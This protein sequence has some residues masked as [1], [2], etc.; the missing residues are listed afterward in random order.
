[1]SAHRLIRQHTFGRKFSDRENPINAGAAVMILLSDDNG[2]PSSFRKK[3]T[4][5][6]NVVSK[7]YWIKEGCLSNA[8]L[9]CS[10]DMSAEYRAQTM[11]FSGNKVEVDSRH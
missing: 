1:M 6:R 5:G 3:L 10:T 4:F 2:I 11:R 9:I 7:L 8:V